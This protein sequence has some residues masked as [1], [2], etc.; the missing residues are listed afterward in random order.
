[1]KHCVKYPDD[2]FLAVR[3]CL[4][5]I[6]LDNRPAAKLLGALLYRY[7]LR[8]EN[9]DDAENHNAV[10]SAK[11]EQ[12]DQDISYRIFRRQ[13]Q[14]VDDM[15]GEL[16]EKTLHDV[17]VPMLQLLGYLDLEEYM[18]ANCYILN[19][20]QIQQA[21]DLYIPTNETQSKLRQF[22]IDHIRLENFLITPAELE[23][24]LIDKKYFLLQLEKVLIQNRKV[25][26]YKRGR[27]GTPEDGSHRKN[28]RLKNL[29]E[30]TKK[31][32]EEY[33]NASA[34][35]PTQSSENDSHQPPAT[36]ETQASVHIATSTPQT[37][38]HVGVATRN[39]DSLFNDVPQV[40]PQKPTRNTSKRGSKRKQDLEAITAEPPP[41]KPS[42]DI[43]WNVLT[44][45]ALADY[46]RGYTLTNGSYG[47][48][49]EEAKKLIQRGKTY[50]QVDATFRY[51]TGTEKKEDGT[52]LFDEYWQDKTVDIW[53]VNTHIDA[54]LKEIKE[55][56]NPTQISQA[57][58]GLAQS[59]SNTRNLDKE[60]AEM[61]ARY[62][63]KKA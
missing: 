13:S 18:Q 15:C 48:A 35:T 59:I 3:P 37:D 17:A 29:K 20:E 52:G 8:T 60:M 54:K 32:I 24:S 25:S 33:V 28:K 63:R 58:D 44:C 47:K 50:R 10:K 12:P 42:L 16:T 43:P 7:N 61:E 62:S 41:E 39:T 30:I 36:V 31:N 14:L 22:V 21:L 34:L 26:N 38:A 51:M 1:M 27:K 4:V 57:R 23:K 5:A 9:K 40:P 11:G 45:M 2:K 6:C 19:M 46:Y 49:L 53:H 55:K 56:R